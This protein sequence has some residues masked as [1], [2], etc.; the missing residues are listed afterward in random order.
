M[1]R[2]NL[3][4]NLPTKFRMRTVHGTS[5]S[6]PLFLYY[7]MLSCS[8][9]CLFM[10]LWLHKLQT[11]SMYQNKSRYKRVQKYASLYIL[12]CLFL[13]SVVLY[14]LSL[15]PFD[16]S[17]EEYLLSLKELLRVN[18]SIA[19]CSFISDLQL[20]RIICYREFL[21]TTYS[22]QIHHNTDC[23]SKRKGRRFVL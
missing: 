18:F 14:L 22:C 1:S 17:S 19:K 6:I 12:H 10:I 2:I 21:R 9:L 5:R 16:D 20:K 13:I 3:H 8:V 4:T 11:I 23:L 15:I 7:R